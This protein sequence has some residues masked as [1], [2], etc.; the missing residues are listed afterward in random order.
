MCLHNSKAPCPFSGDAVQSCSGED[1]GFAALYTGNSRNL[2]VQPQFFGTHP[3]RRS[4]TKRV[5]VDPGQVYRV[6]RNVKVLADKNRKKNRSY[7]TTVGS[8]CVAAGSGM[9]RVSTT[10]ERP[11]AIL[12]STCFWGK[13]PK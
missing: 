11:S 5:Q 4:G 6:A 9:L 3:Q 1:V 10:A 7:C 8:I 2:E 13:R 12:T